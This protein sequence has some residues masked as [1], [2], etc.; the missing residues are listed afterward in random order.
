MKKMSKLLPEHPLA[1]LAP[2]SGLVALLALLPLAAWAVHG[3][4]AGMASVETATKTKWG[5]APPNLPKGAKLS[6]LSGDPGKPGPFVLRLAAPANYR[7][8]PHWH[9]NL[10]SVTVISG[11][12]YL[13]LG[14]KFDKKALHAY[15]A[16]GY[17]SLPGKTPHFAYTKTPTVVQVHGEGPLD[18]TYVNPDD[19]P[20][21]M[22]ANK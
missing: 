3:D 1:S 21:K 2:L 8:A 9:T 19:D 12:F 11:T 22:A 18:L 13:G 6:V 20:Q 4:V 5:E 16:G 10:E 14:E 15:K 17:F 7:V